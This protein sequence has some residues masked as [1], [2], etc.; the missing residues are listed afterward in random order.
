M[1]EKAAVD[2]TATSKICKVDA[3]RRLFTAIVLEPWDGDPETADE[4]SDTQDDVVT[5]AEIETAAY[6]F[7]RHFGQGETFLGFMHGD[8]PAPLELA[9]SW[10]ARVD[11]DF[12][13]GESAK[14]GTWLMTIYVVDDALWAGVLSGEYDGLSIRGAGYR[15][16]V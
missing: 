6:L 16:E 5:A 13:N 11:L 12:G 14:A 7:L 8:D 3:P 4:S 10:I 15:T 1:T 2:I 9:E